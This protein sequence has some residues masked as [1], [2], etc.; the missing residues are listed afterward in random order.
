MKIESP[1]NMYLGRSRTRRKRVTGRGRAGLAARNSNRRR[2]GF[3]GDVL[4]SRLSS[5]LKSAR[6]LEI[7]R[8]VNIHAGN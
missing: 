6:G 3:V 5:G 4:S 7:S 1:R 8:A 2:T